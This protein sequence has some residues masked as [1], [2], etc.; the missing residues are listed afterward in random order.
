MLLDLASI[1]KARK[2]MMAMIKIITMVVCSDCR[3]VIGEIFD[4]LSRSEDLEKGG[5]P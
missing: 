3:R 4:M 1:S 2:L 5:S